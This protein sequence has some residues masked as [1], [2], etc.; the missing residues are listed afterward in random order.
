MS[1]ETAATSLVDVVV[2]TEMERMNLSQLCVSSA[3]EVV[4]PGLLPLC[5]RP[6]IWYSLH[7]W[8]EA[9]FPYVFVCAVEGNHALSEYL[10]QAFPQLRIHYV[11]VPAYVKGERSTS[12]DA[13]RAYLNYKQ[14]LR[15]RDDDEPE[16]LTPAAGVPRDKLREERAALEAEPR[17][18]VLVGCE[19]VLAGV[20]LLPLVDRFYSSLASVTALLFRP[21]PRKEEKKAAGGKRHGPPQAAEPLPVAHSFSCTAYEEDDVIADMTAGARAVPAA[22]GPLHHRLHFLERL[23][24][25]D[26]K[27]GVT[28]AF[29]ARRPNL[30]F[31][32]DTVDMRLYVVRHWVL[33]L[34]AETAGDPDESVEDT[35]I[36]RL[37]RSQHTTVNVRVHA[38]Q[39]PDER[40]G[41][42]IPPYWMYTGH[43][44]SVDSLNAARG[45]VLPPRADSLRV[46]ATIYEERADLPCKLYRVDSCEAY[47]AVTQELL[48]GKARLMELD[49]AAPRASTV[50]T[51]APAEDEALRSRSALAASVPHNPLTLTAKEGDQRLH[52]VTSYVSDASELFNANVTKSVIGPGVVLAEGATVRNS[53]LLANVVVGAKCKIENS[54]LGKG[55]IVKDGQ[56]VRRSF[57]RGGCS[58]NDDVSNAV[59]E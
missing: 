40:I 47:L 57:V 9:G 44:S 59:V 29:A 46:F 33:Q 19:T 51:D 31:A 35:V 30:T 41:F 56:T 38:S 26:A 15:L 4:P 20:P 5:N 24:E 25:S 10:R 53:V 42:A 32:A 21:L 2:L 37:V 58:V 45:T 11:P 39:T 8:V 14:Q 6:L 48:E 16:P 55:A 12:C 50:G 36:P 1:I 23:E 49:A 7:P 3:K 34:I 18:A 54:V 28:M 13:V 52:I 22:G 27:V 43:Q 17:D